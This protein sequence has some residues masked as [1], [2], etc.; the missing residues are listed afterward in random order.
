M[1]FWREVWWRYLEPHYITKT[2]QNIPLIS[3]DW[4]LCVC[5]WERETDR[6]VLLF[7]DTQLVR[8]YSIEYMNMEH[9]WND[10]DR[11]QLKY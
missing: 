5:V 11:G 8:L 2:S 4:N 1:E 9:W 6:S 3:A 7:K 10:T